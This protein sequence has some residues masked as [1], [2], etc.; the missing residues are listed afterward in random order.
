VVRYRFT[1]RG[2]VL[3]KA[4]VAADDP[5]LAFTEWAST[6]DDDAYADL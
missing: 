1:A 5:F 3:E 4:E 2:I 6:N